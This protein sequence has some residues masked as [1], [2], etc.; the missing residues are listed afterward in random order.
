MQSIPPCALLL[1]LIAVAE[2]VFGQISN[3]NSQAIVNKHNERRRQ[4]AKGLVRDAR[5]R[6]QKPAA[7]MTELV[8]GTL[9]YFCGRYY[10]LKSRTS[11]TLYMACILQSEAK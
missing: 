8:G 9:V 6:R 5:G 3:R 11:P 10:E 1:L 7:D 2:G 4:V